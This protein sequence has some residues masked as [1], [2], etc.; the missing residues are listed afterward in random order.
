MLEILNIDTVTSWD[1]L[2]SKEMMSRMA[3]FISS[4]NEMVKEAHNS[5]TDIG[6]ILQ[7]YAEIEPQQRRGGG[8]GPR[9]GNTRSTLLDQEFLSFLELNSSILTESHW[10]SRNRALLIYNVPALWKEVTVNF[11][12]EKFKKILKLYPRIRRYQIRAGLIVTRANRIIPTTEAYSYLYPSQNFALTKETFHFHSYS[13]PKASIEAL[14]K[15]LNGWS[16]ESFL[17]QI[18]NKIASS[19]LNTTAIISNLEFYCILKV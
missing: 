5:G 3:N 10:L 4:S 18:K 2:E 9:R 11:I 19:S 16:E 8:G 1:I 13:R 14:S 7:R 15:S 6:L 17:E 12:L